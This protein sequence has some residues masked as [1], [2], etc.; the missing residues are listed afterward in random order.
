MVVL[1]FVWQ[2]QQKPPSQVVTRVE[3]TNEP[4]VLVCIHE[5]KVRKRKAWWVYV[6]A[7]RVMAMSFSTFEHD[8]SDQ[9]FKYGKKNS[10]TT[11]T[12]D[13]VK[14][15]CS[16]S[17]LVV[18]VEQEEKGEASPPPPTSVVV[19]VFCGGI[20]GPRKA[21]LAQELAFAWQRAGE[22]V[23]SFEFQPDYTKWWVSLLA[24]CVHRCLF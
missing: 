11:V 13:K 20:K 7:C 16:R 23:F 18:K 19:P 14:Q 5:E 22:V 24:K 15:A 8:A 12:L 2:L 21:R 1:C 3:G 4:M 17:R 9:W 6:Q 10:R